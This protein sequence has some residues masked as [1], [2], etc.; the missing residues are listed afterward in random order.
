MVLPT[1]VFRS[2]PDFLLQSELFQDRRK[3]LLVRDPRDTIVSGYFSIAY[4]H[5]VPDSNKE[6]VDGLRES[7][8][9]KR[10][11]T[12]AQSIDQYSIENADS[13][14]GTISKYLQLVGSP[15]L[16]IYRYEDVVMNKQPW[17]KDMAD[18]LDLELPDKLLNRILKR[19]DVV[20]D[21]E[22]P[23][24][25]VRRVTPGDHKD[26]LKPETIAYLDEVFADFMKSFSY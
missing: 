24:Q 6:N 18:F 3:V 1:L 10:E 11:L 13:L 8:L 19:L 12:Q 23:D 14:N 26:K 25:H 5:K 22:Q 16:K 20:P 9:K 21:Q 7:M 4:S 2:L 15:N 17:I